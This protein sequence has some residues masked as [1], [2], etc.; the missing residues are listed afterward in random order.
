MSQTVR[1]FKRSPKPENQNLL[2]L[3]GDSKSCN[4]FVSVPRG[5][6]NHQTFWE[7]SPVLS[8]LSCLQEP[9]ALEFWVLMTTAAVLLPICRVYPSPTPE[10]HT[11]GLRHLRKM[12]L[13]PHME[14]IA[15]A[16]AAEAAAALAIRRRLRKSTRARVTRPSSR[17]R[18]GRWLCFLCHK[19]NRGYIKPVSEIKSHNRRSLFLMHLFVEL[20]NY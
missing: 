3:L 12:W 9:R 19:T 20:Q 1:S 7:L 10:H 14:S 8:G 16:A 15:A 13:L 5:G 6:K 2:L 4:F 18:G 17:R 11:Y